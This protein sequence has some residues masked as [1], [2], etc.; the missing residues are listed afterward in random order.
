MCRDAVE[1]VFGEIGK[2]YYT[3]LNSLAHSL[4]GYKYEILPEQQILSTTDPKDAL[5]IYCREIMYRLH[6]ASS[7]AVLRTHRWIHGVLAASS[8]KNFLAFGASFRGLLE[9]AGDIADTFMQIPIAVAEIHLAVKD[10]LQKKSSVTVDLGQ[11]EHKLI[12]FQFARKLKKGEAELPHHKAKSNTDYIKQLQQ[13]GETSMLECYYELCQ[14][15]HPAA[16][17]VMSFVRHDGKNLFTLDNQMD[18]LLIE[19]FCKRY[20]VVADRVLQVSLN[21]AI[22]V[23]KLLNLLPLPELRT[24]AADS[25]GFG[26]IPLW[27]KIE[28]TLSNQ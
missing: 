17:S 3:G 22:C 10:T 19:D 21:P 5:R 6:W 16:Q 18:G 13:A 9:S 27:Q 4:S 28:K 14:L 20:S 12:H 11:L 8:A 23:L 26:N 24:P 2:N 15:A 7:T 25:I 1:V